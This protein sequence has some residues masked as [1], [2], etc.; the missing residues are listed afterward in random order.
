MICFYLFE[1]DNSF[2]RDLVF[3]SR[4]L[5]LYVSYVLAHANFYVRIFVDDD[6][7]VFGRKTL[8]NEF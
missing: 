8:H 1:Y 7:G 4:I 6:F 3:D 5:T 2:A